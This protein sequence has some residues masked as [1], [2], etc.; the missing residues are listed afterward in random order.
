[1]SDAAT[2]PACRILCV[3]DSHTRGGLG[4]SYVAELRKLLAPRTSTV[5][6]SGVDGQQAIAVRRRMAAAIRQHSTVAPPPGA[7]RADENSN[8]SVASCDLVVVLLVGTNDCIANLWSEHG[9]SE[10]LALMKKNNGIDNET[11]LH[12]CSAAHFEHQYRG[13]VEAALHCPSVKAVLCV[14]LPVLGEDVNSEGW[15]MVEQY[16]EL[17]KKVV[18]E[19]AVGAKAPG[20]AKSSSPKSRVQFVDAWSAMQREVMGRTANGKGNRKQIMSVASTTSTSEISSSRSSSAFDPTRSGR[21]LLLDMVLGHF[22][23]KVASYVLPAAGLSKVSE[24]MYGCRLL[25]DKIHMN[26]VGAS[27]MAGEILKAL[28]E[29]GCLL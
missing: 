20:A 25:S 2:G 18:G 17:V 23:G 9:N 6:S 21:W 12:W 26:D 28:K 7:T 11:Q 16:N 14:S 1:M 10:M 29:N 15:K 3:G 5:F 4:G 27:V 24:Y 22:A 13:C 19:F 8:S